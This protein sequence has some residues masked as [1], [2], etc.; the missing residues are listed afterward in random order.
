VL[1]AGV[2]HNYLFILFIPYCFI[3]YQSALTFLTEYEFILFF[4]RGQSLKP[5]GLIGMAF[6]SSSRKLWSGVGLAGFAGC[7]CK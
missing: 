7:A 5:C 4:V 6:A 2:I 1:A 3:L